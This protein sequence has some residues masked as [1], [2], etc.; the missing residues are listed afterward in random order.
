ML[1]LFHRF[2]GSRDS[3]DLFGFVRTSLSTGN[4]SYF[5]I[6]RS[7]LRRYVEWFF[8]LDHFKEWLRFF[9]TTVFIITITTILMIVTFVAVRRH[10]S[11]HHSNHG[12]CLDPNLANGINKITLGVT[13]ITGEYLVV[14]SR[15]CAHDF[16]FC[17][18]YHPVGFNR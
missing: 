10:T 13:H 14:T 3:L 8:P 18:G 12:E 17:Q 5:C 7:F 11:V 1:W 15:Q 6:I 9:V 16:S 2:V 4:S